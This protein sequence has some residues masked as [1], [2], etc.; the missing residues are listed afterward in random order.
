MTGRRALSLSSLLVAALVSGDVLAEEEESADD[1]AETALAAA[2]NMYLETDFDGADELLAAA[3]ARCEAET[4]KRRLHARLHVMRAEV[5][6][7]GLQKKE[8]A[9]EAMIAALETEPELEL[10]QNL[11]SQALFALYDEA[12]KELE[13]RRL[14]P[15]PRPADETGTAK[16]Q[17]STRSADPEREPEE[18]RRNWI[19]V[20]F[21]VDLTLLLG[22]EDVCSPSVQDDRGWFCTRTDE[23]RYRGVPTVGQQNT[24]DANLAL[25]TMRA[26]VGYERVL[27]DN[28][29]LGLRLG[30]VF[31]PVVSGS[32]EG[33]V[34]FHGEGRVAYWFGESPFADVVRPNL[35]IAAGFGPVITPAELTVVEDGTAC[36]AV[37]PISGDCAVATDPARDGPEPRVQ[38]LQANKTAGQGFGSLGFGLSFSPT[39][40]LMIDFGVRVSATFPVFTPVLSPEAGLSFGF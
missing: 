25:S 26:V 17:K 2:E 23:S 31:R 9:K 3:V 8:E 29:T 10:D 1:Y 24:V 32:D 5:L 4:C 15:E 12:K 6:V 38:R 18:I 19:R 37:D 28:F 21:M 39:P 33:F 20:A 11:D 13:N 35:F 27:G 40:V 30:Y 14:R 34:P 7:S 36:G 16:K 22:E